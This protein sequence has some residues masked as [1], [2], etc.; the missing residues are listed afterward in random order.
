MLRSAVVRGRWPVLT[1]LGI[2]HLERLD[3]G[4]VNE[5]AADQPREALKLAAASDSTEG[6]PPVLRSRR[7]IN[8]AHAQVHSRDNADAVIT[9]RRACSTA[10][11]FVGC[12]P[13]ARTLTNELLTR[14]DAQRLDGLA[15][16]AEHLAYPSDI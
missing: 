2:E 6:V 1:G 15:E 11:E 9:L 16:V 8:V 13:L 5:I 14:R 7:L 4:V 3:I 10:P 12:I